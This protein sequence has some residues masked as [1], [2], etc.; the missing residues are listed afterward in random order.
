MTQVAAAAGSGR[1]TLGSSS[2][3]GAGRS[4]YTSGFGLYRFSAGGVLLYSPL[5]L[6]NLLAALSPESSLCFCAVG[7]Q[8]SSLSFVLLALQFV[9]HCSLPGR[10]DKLASPRL[11][12]RHHLNLIA[13][14]PSISI[15][16]LFSRLALLQCN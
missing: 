1:P 10:L 6:G 11:P 16:S 15:V 4:W 9:Y 8:V 5:V 7:L 14:N 3:L 2:P 12:V 13:S